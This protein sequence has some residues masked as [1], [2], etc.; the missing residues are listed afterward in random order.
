MPSCSPW[1]TNKPLLLFQE[2][3]QIVFE[4]CRLHLLHVFSP[5]S[6]TVCLIFI[7]WFCFSFAS[8]WFLKCYGYMSYRINSSMQIA[9]FAHVFFSSSINIDLEMSGGLYECHKCRWRMFSYYQ[10]HNLQA[11]LKVSL[12]YCLGM[13]L[14]LIS[15]FLF[16]PGS[17]LPW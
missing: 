5:Q 1:S 12:I 4:W 2:P 14:C 3:V 11:L 15:N 13:L 17:N 16:L 6:H 10:S 8:L 7:F 9:L